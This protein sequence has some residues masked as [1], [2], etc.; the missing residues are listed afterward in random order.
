MCREHSQTFPGFFAK[1]VGMLTHS[2]CNM[3]TNFNCQ[4]DTLWKHLGKSLKGGLR[5]SVGLVGLSL[6]VV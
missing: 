1:P 4:L 6:G 2:V 5:G 3:M